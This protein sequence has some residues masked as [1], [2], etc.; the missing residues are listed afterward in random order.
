MVPPSPSTNYPST[1][2]N[3]PF[4]IW[5]LYYSLGSTGSYCQNS[6][7]FY[8]TLLCNLASKDPQYTSL[9]SLQTWCKFYYSPRANPYQYTLWQIEIHVEVRIGILGG[10]GA[11]L[12]V[13]G[14]C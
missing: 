13:R 3:T 4:Q 1:N 9:T 10:I 2:H 6:C 5:F 11:V 7:S 12:A 8:A 14:S